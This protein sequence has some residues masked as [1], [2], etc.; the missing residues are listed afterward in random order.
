[1]KSARRPLAAALMM[2]ACSPLFAQ[3][4]QDGLSNTLLFNEKLV[5]P[6]PA[7]RTQPADPE[8]PPAS[9][10]TN[11]STRGS[12]TGNITQTLSGENAVEQ[13]VSV[14]GVEVV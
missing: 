8:A 1:M 3:S 14:A 10:V 9:G 12:L 5:V 4:I 11:L 2:L 13:S 7:V 6:L